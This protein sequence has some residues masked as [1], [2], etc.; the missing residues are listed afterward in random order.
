MRWGN[1]LYE[2][3]RRALGTREKPNRQRYPKQS[4]IELQIH[5]ETFINLCEEN[6]GKISL[7]ITW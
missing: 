6:R 7:F 5:T 3:N 4:D 1:M 2:A